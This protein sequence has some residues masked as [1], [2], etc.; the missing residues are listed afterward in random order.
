[1]K[2]RNK[3]IYY[4]IQIY[5]LSSFVITSTKNNSIQPKKGIRFVVR[6]KDKLVWISFLTSQTPPHFPTTSFSHG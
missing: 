1:M 5:F 6:I 3:T 2:G 4:P